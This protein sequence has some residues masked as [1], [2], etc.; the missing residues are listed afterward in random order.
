VKVWLD[1]GL[2]PW[3]V[4]EHVFNVG[5]GVVHNNDNPDAGDGQMIW[6]CP[7]CGWVYRCAS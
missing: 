4:W 1:L 5:H 2:L 3:A 6:R 7:S